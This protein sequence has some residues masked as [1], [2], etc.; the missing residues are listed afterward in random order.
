M[1]RPP[2]RTALTAAVCVA[3][4]L[5]VG[6]ASPG[7]AASGASADAGAT[8]AAAESRLV[9]TD[10]TVEPGETASHRIALTDAPNGLAGFKL[11]LEL[12]T[13]DATISDAAYP[14]TYGKTT[15]PH[16][17]D[18]GQSVTV[19]AAD[20]TDEVT[21]GATDVTLATVEVHGT[22]AGST[23]L[24]VTGMQAD[25]DGGDRIAPSLEAGT[26]TV[27]DD[28]SAPTETQSGRSADGTERDDSIPGFAAGTTIV[29]LAALVVAL[30]A[31]SRRDPR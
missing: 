29:A 10:A 19:E 8:P 2:R 17:S 31:R 12:S 18:D 1:G 7:M 30:L 5:A 3:V 11:T 21:A 14:D 20:L 28:G 23:A 25:A 16:V 27:T 6:L 9:V 24:E 4:G 15:P 13:D 26:L 22:D